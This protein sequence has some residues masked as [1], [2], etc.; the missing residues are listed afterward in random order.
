MIILNMGVYILEKL[1]ITGK[2]P[3]KGE[4]V[5]S[6]AKN[7][8]VAIIPAT[9]LINGICRIE[10]LPNINQMANNLLAI[11]EKVKTSSPAVLTGFG[12][13]ATVA[14][15]L[16]DLICVVQKYTGVKVVFDITVVRGQGY[17]TGTV[18]ECYTTDGG[19]NR[20]IG[21]GGRYDKMLEKFLGVNVP[22]VGYSIGLDPVVM[23]LKEA[24][25]KLSSSK[26]A[27]VYPKNASINAVFDAKTQLI[28]KKLEISAFVEPT[29]LSSDALESNVNKNF[30]MKARW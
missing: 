6:G 25:V 30:N 13:D 9:L 14:Q 4:V 2:T 12:V 1:V 5:I 17:Y 18:F 26:I 15:N 16:E 8:A 27:L 22:A 7:A 28:A 3:L 10:N 20:A 19:F 23:L 24:N 21:G 11:I 29:L